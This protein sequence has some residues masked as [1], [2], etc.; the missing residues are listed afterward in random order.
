MF[1][2]REFAVPSCPVNADGGGGGGALASPLDVARTVA[3]VVDA[4]CAPLLPVDA[5]RPRPDAPDAP[6][7]FLAPLLAAAP[8]AATDDEPVTTE[9]VTSMYAA[10]AVAVPVDVDEETVAVSRTRS[11]LSSAALSAA[12]DAVTVNHDAAVFAA[13]TVVPRLVSVPDPPTL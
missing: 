8:R 7:V 1:P 12:V 4:P 3:V 9:Y 6:G 13:M 10:Y 5:A 11:E 2:S